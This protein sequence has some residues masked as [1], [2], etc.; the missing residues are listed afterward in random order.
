MFFAKFP[1]GRRVP[2]P[3]KQ[4]NLIT[5]EEDK[6]EELEA[7]GHEGEMALTSY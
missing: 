7:M 5:V 2:P 4:K 6:K 1:T 3:P